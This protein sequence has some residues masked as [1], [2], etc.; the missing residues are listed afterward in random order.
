M[1]R[2]WRAELLETT[3]NPDR[4]VRKAAT[5]DLCPWQIKVNDSEV[6]ERI[7]AM[8]DDPESEV[9][10]IALHAILDGSA[11]S[12]RAEVVRAPRRDVSRAQSEAPETGE[13]G[14]R[15]TQ[16]ATGRVNFNAH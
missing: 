3:R 1:R 5:R 15:P 9:R 2:Y 8:T 6:W 10:R 13:V 7:I 4:K 14:T 11:P 12:R 16:R